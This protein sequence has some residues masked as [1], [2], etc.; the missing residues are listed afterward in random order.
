M[1]K[2]EAMKK[3]T[4]KAVAKVAIFVFLI[5]VLTFA[6]L[7]TAEIQAFAEGDLEHSLTVDSDWKKRGALRFAWR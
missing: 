6:T 4:K 3:A 1:G 7:F 5:V 2:S